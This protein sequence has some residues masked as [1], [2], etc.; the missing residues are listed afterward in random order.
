[1]FDDVA[2]GK[3]GLWSVNPPRPQQAP[4]RGV[5]GL[6]GGSSGRLSGL[7]RVNKPCPALACLSPT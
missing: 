7:A 4:S 2:T 6:A 3:Y 5:V 1:M